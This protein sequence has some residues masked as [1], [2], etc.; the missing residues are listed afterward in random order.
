M[1]VLLVAHTQT[2]A[3]LQQ[4]GV[5][6]VAAHSHQAALGVDLGA[7]EGLVRNLH[8]VYCLSFS[9][10]VNSENLDGKY[11]RLLLVENVP[12]VQYSVLPRC[13]EN[14]GSGGAPTSISQILSVGA[15]GGIISKDLAHMTAHLV[16]MMALSLMSS[17]QIL[18][19]QSPTV[20]KF[21]QANNSSTFRQ[22]LKVSCK[23]WENKDFS[24]EHRQD[25]S[26]PGRSQQF[27]L[28][29][30]WLSCCRQTHFL[31]ENCHH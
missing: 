16:H 24:E 30:S 19:H 28:L 8:T 14:R 13:E 3:Q 10:E 1:A 29:D 7:V 27:S 11:W 23:P 4:A 21:C 5:P 31:A 18:A 17:D 2:V 6:V 12:G 26:G 15:T 25:H 20:R 22:K 9:N